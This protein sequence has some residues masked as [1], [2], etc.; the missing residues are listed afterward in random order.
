MMGL[1]FYDRMRD[2]FE[3]V[4]DSYRS[5]CKQYS[6][7]SAVVCLNRWCFLIRKQAILQLCVHMKSRKVCKKTRS[8][9]ASLLFKCQVTEHITVKWPIVL[10]I[11]INYYCSVIYRFFVTSITKATF[12]QHWKNFPPAKKSDQILC[13]HGTVQYLR[14]VHTKIWT[15]RRLLSFRTIS[16]IPC[17]QNT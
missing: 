1:W 11:V 2:S 13:S 16:V 17:E 10:L 12:I 4:T 15:T 7:V 14:S 9:P 5:C 3:F 6:I 8:P